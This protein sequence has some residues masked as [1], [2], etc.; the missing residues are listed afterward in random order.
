MKELT[1]VKMSPDK[2]SIYGFPNKLKEFP[3]CNAYVQKNSSKNLST[4]EVGPVMLILEACLLNII[5]LTSY[6][7]VPPNHCYSAGLLGCL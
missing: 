4:I 5:S 3:I 2:T 6:F 1:L 7:S